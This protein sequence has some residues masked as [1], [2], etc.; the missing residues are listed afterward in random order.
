MTVILH[1]GEP[2]RADGRGTTV[3]APHPAERIQ[4]V[5]RL[6]T[7]GLSDREIGDELGLTKTSVEKIRRR[8]GIPAG[9]VIKVPPGTVETIRAMAAVGATD[10]E[11]GQAVG[12][13]RG[14]VR[15]ARQRHGVGAGNPQLYH[16][17]GTLGMYRSGCRCSQCTATSRGVAKRS[18]VRARERLKTGSDQI[19]HGVEGYNYW[20]CRCEECKEAAAA[21]TRR[22][23]G[24]YQSR[25]LSQARNYGKEWTGPELELAARTDLT[26]EEVASMLGR[27]YA[28]VARMRER[29]QREPK[30]A[31]VA[32]ISRG[33]EA[34]HRDE[35]SGV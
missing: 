25:T 24:A 7:Q 5:R 17:H 16:Q 9:K 34:A 12:M 31:N 30:Y 14:A 26:A 15:G 11:I 18:R 32:G 28:A 10:G 29:L 2:S 3:A 20:G 21:S 35:G 4:A 22:R 19:E 23:R 1:S 33:S 8:T 6:A 13:S 27:T